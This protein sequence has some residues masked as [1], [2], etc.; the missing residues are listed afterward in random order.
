MTDVDI[1]AVHSRGLERARKIV[2]AFIAESVQSNNE[3]TLLSEAFRAAGDAL[4]AEADAATEAKKRGW[5][6]LTKDLRNAAGRLV[7]IAQDLAE[8]AKLEPAEPKPTT[9]DDVA[10]VFDVPREL[11]EPKYPKSTPEYAA[12]ERELKTELDKFAKG[13]EP[14]PYTDTTDP[15]TSQADVAAYLRGETGTLPAELT[16]EERRLVQASN[17]AGAEGAD[18]NLSP[19]EKAHALADLT[20]GPVEQ[21]DNPST[22]DRDMTVPTL[23]FAD[24]EPYRP[25]GVSYVPEGVNPDEWRFDFARLSTRPDPATIPDH[26]SWSQL[27]S[28]EDCGVKYRLQRL[29][30]VPQ[31]PMWSNVGGSTF[32][33]VTEQ[34]DLG[35]WRAGGADLLPETHPELI[36][37][38]WKAAFL[39]EIEKTI[40]ETGV[41]PG[42]EMDQ[43]HAAQG[44][45]EGYTW[46]LVE[47]ERMLAL[48]VHNR[49]TLDAAARQ[50]GTVRKPLMLMQFVQ[51][52]SPGMIDTERVPVIEYAYSRKVD[53]PTGSLTVEG[54]IDRAYEC[55]DGSLL[56]VDLKTGRS[57]PDAAQ[58]GEY[59]QALANLLGQH[60]EI[61]GV[62]YDARKGI[63]TD[64]VDLFDAH[65]SA[66]YAYRYHAAQAM[67]SMGVYLPRKSN[68]CVSCSVRWA[69]PVGGA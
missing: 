40:E 13:E 11:I 62:F 33:T 26:W 8:L 16:D 52:G 20:S 49:R 43:W 22:G 30:G 17:D 7:G 3:A 69:C 65:P 31:R 61:R 63:Y 12:Y 14:Y 10:R 9:A 6:S 56:V 64:P 45:K 24:P 47:G 67:R 57:Q 37:E 48:Y 5:Q 60:N 39:A 34:F 59:G 68:Y 41:K 2:E 4:H 36:G 38:R 15:V 51:G 21:Y 32:H 66:E 50:A 42:P 35:A 46:W 23:G 18:Y 53:G 55:S 58:L 44:G 28:L 54:V 1:E 19:I 25:T 29:E 27:T